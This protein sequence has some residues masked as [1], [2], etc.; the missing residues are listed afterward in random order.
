LEQKVHTDQKWVITLKHD[1]FLQQ[2]VVNL[3]ILN[4]DIFPDR[5]N[6]VEFLVLFELSQENF[7]EGTSTDDHQDLEVFE[8]NLLF[9]VLLLDQLGTSELILVHL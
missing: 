1:I 5:L 2:S 7:S 4:E 8:D 6:G 9:F 3:V